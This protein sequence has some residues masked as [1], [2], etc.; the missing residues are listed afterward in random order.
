MGGRPSCR[1]SGGNR[2]AGAARP[3][4]ELREA[5]PP[6]GEANWRR[7]G[8]CLVEFQSRQRSAATVASG[9]CALNE[10]MGIEPDGSQ[11][12]QD[13]LRADEPPLGDRSL[14][15]PSPNRQ[16]MLTYMLLLNRA[17]RSGIRRYRWAKPLHEV[18]PCTQR[19]CRGEGSGGALA[20]CG[21]QPVQREIG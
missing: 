3:P 21:W 6:R 16:S 14:P 9:S 8:C 12:S 2:E 20:D 5:L 19:S 7:S 11:C 13:R 17:G 18:A 10:R 4:S 15:A 1:D